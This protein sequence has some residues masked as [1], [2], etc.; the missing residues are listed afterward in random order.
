MSVQ[1]LSS[2][3]YKTLLLTVQV[4]GNLRQSEVLKLKWFRIVEPL[5]ASLRTKPMTMR[6]GI[7]PEKSFS[8]FASITALGI[9]KILH[10]TQFIGYFA[11]KFFSALACASNKDEDSLTF[12]IYIIALS[13]YTLDALAAGDNLY[14][15]SFTS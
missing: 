13:M 11:V 6:V 3:V 12:R 15:H 10:T 1:S 7:W 14:V 2:E 8:W 4:N 9:V 5:K